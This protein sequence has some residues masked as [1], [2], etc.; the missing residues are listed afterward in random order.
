MNTSERRRMGLLSIGEFASVS[1][2]TVKALRHWDERGLLRPAVASS[3]TGYRYYRLDQLASVD[4]LER[5]KALGLPLAALRSLAREE[6]FEDLVSLPA[7]AVFEVAGKRLTEAK[8]AIRRSEVYL[9]DAKHRW[10]E[11]MALPDAVA[12][13]AEKPARTWLFSTPVYPPSGTGLDDGALQKL[14]SDLLEAVKASNVL[15]GSDWGLLFE[16]EADGESVIPLRISVRGFIACLE[17]VPDA[18]PET[19][20][21]G[22]FESRLTKASAGLWAEAVGVLS[23][24]KASG[25]IAFHLCNWRR[26]E[27]GG[28]IWEAERRLP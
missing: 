17:A 7:E 14:L 16:C 19:I 20:P 11:E 9:E 1:G 28:M 23:A 15:R 21:S 13:E 5:S 3:E 2:I 26:S 18:K 24:P 6:G 12:I 8:T 10:E 4:M 22:R 25:R 27:M